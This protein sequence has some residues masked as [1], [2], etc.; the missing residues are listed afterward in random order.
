[1]ET[2]PCYNRRFMGTC[3]NLK[4]YINRKLMKK[5]QNYIS[6][7]III[8]VKGYW[9]KEVKPVESLCKYSPNSSLMIRQIYFI[10]IYRSKSNT[11]KSNTKGKNSVSIMDWSFLK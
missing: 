4:K 6:S 7:E 2:R 1:M 10:W 11:F 5:Y 8:P 3:R 9:D